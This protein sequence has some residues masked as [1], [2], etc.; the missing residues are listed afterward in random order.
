[1][2]KPEASEVTLQFHISLVT[3]LYRN[4]GVGGLF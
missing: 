1:M 3:T 2:S 4:T